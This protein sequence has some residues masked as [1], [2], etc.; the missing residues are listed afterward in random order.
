MEVSLGKADLKDAVTI[1]NM[2]VKAFMPLLETYQDFETSPANETL[3]SVI[4]QISQSFTDY[5]IIYHFNV[6]APFLFSQNIKEK[7]LLK[8]SLQS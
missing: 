6:L 3:E 5:F 7:A 8:K 1:H 2:K 4:T